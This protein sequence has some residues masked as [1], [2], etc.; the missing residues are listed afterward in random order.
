[1]DIT[2]SM[3]EA[4]PVLTLAGRFD[5][6]GASIFDQQVERLD[7]EIKTWILDLTRVQYLSS[8]G[9]RSLLKAEKRLRQQNGGLVLVGLAPPV[10]QV[11]DM[12][13][14]LISFAPPARW[15]TP[16][17]SFAPAASRPIAR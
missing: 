10:R 3:H 14:L 9:L 15:R 1:M 12:A 13:S 11:L 8:M 5:G 16:C 6:Y 7:Q 17:R 4:V 2:F